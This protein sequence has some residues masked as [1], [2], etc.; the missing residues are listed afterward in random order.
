MKINSQIKITIITID[1]VRQVVQDR[2]TNT[3]DYMLL[4]ENFTI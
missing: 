3:K 4:R 1:G 2:E